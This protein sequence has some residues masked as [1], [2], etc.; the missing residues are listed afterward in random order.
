[1]KCRV[2]QAEADPHSIYC[3]KCGERLEP[4]LEPEPEPADVAAAPLPEETETGQPE[5]EISPQ[6]NAA[7]RPKEVA[8]SAGRADQTEDQP[9]SWTQGGYPAMALRGTCLTVC[10]VTAV[11]VALGIWLQMKGWLAGWTGIAWGLI[12]LVPVV[13]WIRLGCVYVYRVWTIKYRLTPHYFYHEEGIFRR[14]RNVIEVIDIDDIR[15]ERT[16]VDR[17]INGGVG[18]VTIL[19]SDQ[20]SPVLTLRGLAEP[21]KVFESLDEARRKERA[22]RGLKYV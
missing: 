14:V 15:R 5:A 10:L 11:F 19:S 9:L 3:P 13:L 7:E 18:T 17:L 22:A 20:S 6:P 8:A 4:D 16:L 1:M 21:D 12:L 2:C